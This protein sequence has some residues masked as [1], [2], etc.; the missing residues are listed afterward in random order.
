M[1]DPAYNGEVLNIALTDVPEKK[2]DLV[3]GTYDLPAADASSK[4]IVAVKIIDV[5][6]E[7]ILVSKEV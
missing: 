5:L 4:S 3:L 2:N 7:E 1:I 6:G